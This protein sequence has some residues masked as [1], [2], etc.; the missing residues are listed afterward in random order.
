MS[1]SRRTTSFQSVCGLRKA[2]MDFPLIP[3][4]HWVVCIRTLQ[5]TRI[6]FRRFPYVLFRCD[7]GAVKAK[8]E[9]TARFLQYPGTGDF[10]RTASVLSVGRSRRQKKLPHSPEVCRPEQEAQPNEPRQPSTAH[11]LDVHGGQLGDC[12]SFPASHGIP[13]HLSNHRSH[14]PS[15]F[16]SE[17]MEYPGYS[18]AGVHVP[19]HN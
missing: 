17:L 10:P 1:P 3:H 11:F 14:D 12:L 16:Q 18:K 8:D 2:F 13:V 7:A 6:A 4:S 15:P 5:L 19:R 9:M